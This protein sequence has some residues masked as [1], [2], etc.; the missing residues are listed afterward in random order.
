MFDTAAAAAAAVY[1]WVMIARTNDHE[2]TN[3]HDISTYVV[4]STYDR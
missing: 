4:S 3:A 2:T 1:I